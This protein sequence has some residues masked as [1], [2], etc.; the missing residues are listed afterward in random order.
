MSGH[1]PRPGS[2]T[3]RSR[4]AGNAGSLRAG[5]V[6]DVALMGE[7]RCRREE[8]YSQRSRVPLE[9]RRSRAQARLPTW[10][11]WARDAAVEKKDIL[12]GQGYRWSP[13]EAGRPKCWYC[14]LTDADKVVEAAWLRANVMG[15]GQPVWALR[16]T[17][18]DRY[19]DRSWSWGEPVGA[20]LEWAVDR[21]GG[22]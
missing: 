20:A 17:A 2:T 9:S 7:G 21:S 16:I 10:R 6:A 4:A 11:L 22:R 3:P 18:R 1:R 13:G 5:E 14:D 15:P 12:K 19:S 8:G